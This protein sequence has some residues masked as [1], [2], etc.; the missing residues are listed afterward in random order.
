M[1]GINCVW[2]V[3]QLVKYG[4]DVLYPSFSGLLLAT[5][6]HSDTRT[7]RRQRLACSSQVFLLNQKGS[8]LILLGNSF[9]WPTTL[10]FLWYSSQ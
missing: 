3:D 1:W 8:L 7:A 10:G 9:Q 5:G 4:S 2:L 6:G